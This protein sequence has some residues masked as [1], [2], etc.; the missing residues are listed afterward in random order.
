MFTL[1]IGVAVMVTAVVVGLPA[2][3]W[4]ANPELVVV[5]STLVPSTGVLSAVAQ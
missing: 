5:K 4:V 3:G 2:A 1:S